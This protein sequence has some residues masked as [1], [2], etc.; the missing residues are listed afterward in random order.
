MSVVGYTCLFDCKFFKTSMKAFSSKSGLNVFY[1]KKKR[2][3]ERF[4]LVSIDKLIPF[5]SGLVRTICLSYIDPSC[6]IGLLFL[7]ALFNLLCFL[8]FFHRKYSTH[9]Y[10]KTLS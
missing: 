4:A 5:H 7:K 9:F 6:E 3:K 10:S 2:K 8:S 1:E